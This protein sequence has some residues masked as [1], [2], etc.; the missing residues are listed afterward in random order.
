VEAGANAVM[1]RPLE[2]ARLEAWMAK[3]LAVP[4][5]V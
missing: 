1:R 4:L 3:L 2:Q 5:S